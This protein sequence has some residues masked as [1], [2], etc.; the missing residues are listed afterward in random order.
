MSE[1]HYDAFLSYSYAV[2]GRALA[3]AVQSGLS[4]LAKPWYRARA[5]HIFRDQTGLEASPSLGAAI[6]AALGRSRYFILMAS[7]ESAQSVWVGREVE[8]WRLHREQ[9][10]FL[11]VLTS[12]SINWSNGFLPARH[13][14]VDGKVLRTDAIERRQRAA[15]HM[16]AAGAGIRPL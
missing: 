16:I 10:T 14:G 9:K 7:P 12:G 8:H 2:D 11:I 4:R 6:E 1:R 3:P 5:L 13:Q 15:E